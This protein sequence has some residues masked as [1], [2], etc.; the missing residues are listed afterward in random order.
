MPDDLLNRS[1]R[2]II[3]WWTDAVDRDVNRMPFPEGVGG[4][5]QEQAHRNQVP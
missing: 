2:G 1:K 3:D 5:R 4:E